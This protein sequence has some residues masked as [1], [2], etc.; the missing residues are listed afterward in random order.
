MFQA[1]ADGAPGAF[2]P[3]DVFGYIY[4]LLHSPQFRARY[5]DLLRSGF[6][7]IPLHCRPALFPELA[8]LGLEMVWT[9]LLESPAP[10]RPSAYSE[11]IPTASW[12]HTI[13]GIPVLRKWLDDRRGRELTADDRTHFHHMVIAID[14]TRRLT[15][16]IE[17]VIEAQGGIPGAFP[18]E[19]QR[20]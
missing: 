18:H 9:H 11:V 12:E 2:G 15:E 5:A 17:A 7:R 19:T 3:E 14:D 4:A 6:A 16:R 20:A 10:A 13:G 8:K 1:L